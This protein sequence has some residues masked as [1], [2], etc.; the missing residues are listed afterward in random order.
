MVRDRIDRLNFWSRMKRN[1][2][3][4]WQIVYIPMRTFFVGPG[5]E[6]LNKEQNE[7]ESLDESLDIAE[8]ESIDETFDE[9][10]AESSTPDASLLDSLVSTIEETD[11]VDMNAL[12]D[13]EAELASDII[14]RLNAEA[15][16]DAAKK[17]AEI[18]EARAHAEML[19]DPSYNAATGSYSGAYGTGP[20]DDDTMDAV[21]AILMQNN[22]SSVDIDIDSIMNNN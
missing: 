19:E 20:V 18:D 22:R 9:D 5:A 21:S 14:A 2:V 11:P 7:S 8:D 4:V 17:Q 12:S 13:E 6:E 1:I 15:A 3:K 10:F 16:A